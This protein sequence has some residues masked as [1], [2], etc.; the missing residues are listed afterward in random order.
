MAKI[1]AYNNVT[2]EY[3]IIPEHWLN[4]DHP[5]YQ[6]TKEPDKGKATPAEPKKTSITEPARPENQEK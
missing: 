2:G 1:R 5:A 4:I 6:F 3:Q